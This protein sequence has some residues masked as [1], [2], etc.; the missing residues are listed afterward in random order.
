[1]GAFTPD[2]TKS[3]K[4]A[5]FCIA[6]P[7]LI[8]N[9]AASL[10]FRALHATQTEHVKTKAAVLTQQPLPD[11][12][13]NTKFEI[14]DRTYCVRFGDLKVCFYQYVDRQHIRAVARKAGCTKEVYFTPKIATELNVPYNLD[15]AIAY[16]RQFGFKKGSVP[17]AYVPDAKALEPQPANVIGTK[18]QEEAPPPKTYTKP[19]P[20]LHTEVQQNKNRP[21]TGH[22]VQMGLTVR[23]GR[24]GKPPYE[25]YAVMLR[26]ESGGMEKEFIGEHLAELVESHNVAV[27]DLVRIQLLGR[28]RFEVKIG[29][30]MEER[31]RN[32]YSLDLIQ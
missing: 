30:R 5:T 11:I 2:P 6:L 25:T 13:E 18:S 29:N 15:S 26:S 3:E 22:I 21:F 32:E 17:R 4:V 9:A 28:N 23:P 31:T 16:V 19:L 20:R 14:A 12:T 8:L 27:G 24:D 7:F 1:M 10:V